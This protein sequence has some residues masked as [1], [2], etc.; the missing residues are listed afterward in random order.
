MALIHSCF[1]CRPIPTCTLAAKAAFPIVLGQGARMMFAGLIAYGTS[2]TLNVADLL[3]S[4]P[5]ARAQ[6]SVAA[7]RSSPASLSRSSI[8][9][10]FITI[11]FYGE[12][13]IST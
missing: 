12:R 6:P 4:W 13:P 11:S 3:P 9:C 1:S 7:G 8:H 2:Q 5:G 10:M